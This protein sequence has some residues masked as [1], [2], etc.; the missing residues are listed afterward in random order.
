MANRHRG[1]PLREAL[2]CMKGYRD[3]FGLKQLW[4]VRWLTVP[5]V[6]LQLI[7]GAIGALAFSYQ[8]AFENVWMGGA[9]SML[10]GFI[11]GTWLQFN[12]DPAKLHE[13]KPTVVLIGIISLATFSVAVAMAIKG[14][15]G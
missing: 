5:F 15:A 8:T 3:P 12:N 11:I 14:H 4:A 10:P 2:A 6:L 1:R 9:L 7:F 13:N